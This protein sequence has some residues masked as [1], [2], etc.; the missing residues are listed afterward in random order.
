MDELGVH[1]HHD[2][3]LE[4]V[5]S[6]EKRVEYIR[7]N[8]PASEIPLRLRLF[9]LIPPERLPAAL[10]ETRDEG[11]RLWTEGN[12]LRS[13][14]SRLW[15][16]GRR[17][18]AEGDRLWIEGDRLRAEDNRLWIEGDRLWAEGTR[19]WTEGNRL[20]S[21]GNRL[22]DEG[23]AAHMPALLALHAALCPDCP[24]DGKT[25]FTHQNQDGTWY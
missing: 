6:F 13:E 10:G 11:R 22:R 5:T 19:L 24:W 25:I 20:R 17:L 4:I 3:L 9:Q 1:C 8:K 16:E 12:R 23:I 2:V 14:G 15:A 7:A 18:R 21:E